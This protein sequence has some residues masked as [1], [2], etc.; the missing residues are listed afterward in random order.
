MPMT[1]NW[2]KI[3]ATTEE[4][5]EQ[6]ATE[7]GVSADVDMAKAFRV[8]PSSFYRGLR[9]RLGNLSQAEFAL[10]LGLDEQTIVNW[11]FGCAV[12]MGPA[13]VLVRVLEREP[14]AFARAVA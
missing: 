11:E 4:E 14:E 2:E 10:R 1:V 12:P 9:E 3:D 7:D 6:Q 5:I 13:E 8:R